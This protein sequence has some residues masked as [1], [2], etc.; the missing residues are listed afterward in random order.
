MYS[1]SVEGGSQE[2]LANVPA[3][4]DMVKNQGRI[5]GEGSEGDG[6]GADIARGLDESILQGGQEVFGVAAGDKVV[7]CLVEFIVL[8]D[9]VGVDEGDDGFFVFAGFEK[10]GAVLDG[11]GELFGECGL[12]GGRSNGDGRCC[13]QCGLCV[14]NPDSTG[15]RHGSNNCEQQSFL[16]WNSFNVSQYGR[17]RCKDFARKAYFYLRTSRVA[18][19]NARMGWWCWSACVFE[20]LFFTQSFSEGHRVS[21]RRRER[22][23]IWKFI[24]NHNE[25]M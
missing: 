6:V 10:I 7:D 14:E 20:Q 17:S 5:V 15:D 16:H 2:R 13:G 24:Q 8:G 4:F 12:S 21:Q 22:G 25:S 1:T 19:R 18:R 23:T 11:G 9:I 3:V